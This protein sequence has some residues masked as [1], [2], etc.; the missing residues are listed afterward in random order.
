MYQYIANNQISKV[1]GTIAVSSVCAFHVRFFDRK[2]EESKTDKLALS[3]TFSGP[4]KDRCLLDQ[5][6]THKIYP[7]KPYKVRPWRFK[8]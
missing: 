4:D 7:P 3:W 8:A 2:R 6:N 5:V 1:R